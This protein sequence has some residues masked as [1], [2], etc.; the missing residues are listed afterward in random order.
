ML[1]VKPFIFVGV[2]LLLAV[3]G[4]GEWRART[5]VKAAASGYRGAS[6]VN[7]V[8]VLSVSRDL[9]A[10]K[11]PADILNS[12]RAAS[13]RQEKSLAGFYKAVPFWWRLQPGRSEMRL[14]KLAEAESRAL[15]ALTD[16]LALLEQSAE[17]EW[18]EPLKKLN[19]AT[20]EFGSAHRAIMQT[21]IP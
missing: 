20:A 16:S 7:S 10:G 6:E 9:A 2:I 4:W 8:L 1:R 17:N 12:F 15:T 11:K 5:A 3:F 14:I 13:E 18:S 19:Q 21:F